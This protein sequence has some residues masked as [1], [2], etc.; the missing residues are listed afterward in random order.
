ML[1]DTSVGGII[2]TMAERQVKELVEKFFLKE[3]RSKSESGVKVETT[4]TSKGVLTLDTYTSF[5]AHIRHL[6]KIFLESDLNKVN[7]SQVQLLKCDLY[8]EGH[9]NGM[10]SPRGSNEEV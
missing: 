8:G 7:V 3:Y 5:L 2:R 1:L 9:V 10:V 4:G 6:S